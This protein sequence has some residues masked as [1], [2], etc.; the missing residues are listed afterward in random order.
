MACATGPTC[1]GTSYKAGDCSVGGCISACSACSSVCGNTCTGDCENGCQNTCIRGCGSS[2]GGCGNTC[3]GSCDNTCSGNCT[4]CSGTCSGYCGDGCS[5]SCGS[6]C[7]TNCTNTCTG[8]CSNG[9]STT[10]FNQAYTNL[11][12]NDIILDE[13]ITTIVYWIKREGSLK[14]VAMASP[15]VVIGES[16][17]VL[18]QAFNSIMAN[19]QAMGQSLSYTPITGNDIKKASVQEYIDKAKMIY[20]AMLP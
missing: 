18:Y 20:K 4:G 15:E 17:P 1:T 3:S 7:S 12:L 10:S 14:G 19:L 11:V 8:T 6:S 2:C 5:G 9:C 16:V 13:D